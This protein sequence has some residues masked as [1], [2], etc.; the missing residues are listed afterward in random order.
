MVRTLTIDVWS[1]DWYIESGV[2]SDSEDYEII[3]PEPN[4]PMVGNHNIVDGKI[5]YLH[6]FMLAD[7]L[8]KRARDFG[9]CFLEVCNFI[10]IPREKGELVESKK[11]EFEGDFIDA[12]IF[13]QKIL[14]KEGY[15][16]VPYSNKKT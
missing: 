6:D 11:E 1:G 10:Y 4:F 12:F 15:G 8:I 7:K 5:V 16:C 9:G 3:D 14:E 13:I 2:K